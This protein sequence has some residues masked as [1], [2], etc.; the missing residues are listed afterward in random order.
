MSTA[1]LTPTGSPDGIEEPPEAFVDET[2]PLI[3]FAEAFLPFEAVT[4][5]TRSFGFVLEISD[6]ASSSTTRLRAGGMMQRFGLEH[7]S[8][9]I[10]G[11]NWSTCN[12]KTAF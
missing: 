9:V 10:A 6:R 7:K 1:P 12:L 4:E 8:S 2:E 3:V 5:A 11:D